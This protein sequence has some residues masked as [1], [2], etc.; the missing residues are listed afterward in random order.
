MSGENVLSEREREILRLVAEGLTNREIAQKLSISHNT[1]K[2]HLSN[3]FGK[4]GV[5]SRT[6]ATLY[7]IE[8][9]IVDVPGR[10]EVQ[11]ESKQTFWTYI[12]NHR[13]LS[14]V[15]LF[16][17]LL[18]IS[19]IIFAVSNRLKNEEDN[20]G[21]YSRWQ[22]LTPMPESRVGLAVIAYDNQ[23]YAIA[24]EGEAGVSDSVFRYDIEDGNWSLL[25][26]KPTPVTDI[27]GVLI[28]EEIY[29]P[30]GVDANGT[31]VAVLEIYDPRHDTW[32][33]GA[34]LPKPISA[35]AIAGFE[36]KLYLFGGWDGEDAVENVW[37][38]DPTEDKWVGGTAME[39]PLYNV[40]A[41]SFS[42][43]II[44]LGGRNDQEIFRSAQVYYPSRDNH[45]EFPWES[46]PDIP[47]NYSNFSAVVV[48]DIVFIVNGL[49]GT[50]DTNKGYQFRGNWY[51]WA[52]D[53]DGGFTH[54]QLLLVGSDLY[55]FDTLE[56]G[57][58]TKLVRTNQIY[59][60][61]YIP[62]VN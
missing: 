2:V 15:G 17:I 61:I 47:E 20:P 33:T 46:L 49:E 22:E 37:S 18:I 30:G 1:V 23:I 13:L 57:N 16:L 42:D 53:Y 48:S 44:V 3:I 21:S 14:V 52:I 27:G 59:Y 6:E 5:S 29:I 35:Y 45:Q 9:R 62:I 58:Q 50:N 7:A 4:T 40:K 54:P 56:N 36:G 32:R 8:Q 41:V 11:P 26:N 12:S 34:S 28:G 19:S 51:P 24:G 25:H 39:T 31:P 43:K 60:E 38:Y 10:E 55:I